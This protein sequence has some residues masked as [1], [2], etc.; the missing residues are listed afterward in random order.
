MNEVVLRPMHSKD[1]D[2]IVEMEQICFTTPW[3][4]KSIEQEYDNNCAKWCVLEQNDIIIAYGGMWIIFDEAHII[5]IAVHPDYRQRGY[6]TQIMHELFK[7][8]KKE[9]ATRMTLEVRRSNAAAQK[10]YANM[11]FVPVGVRKRY[12]PDNYEDA[13]I[14]WND[15]VAKQLSPVI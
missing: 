6:G 12:Y 7:V 1:I 14:L 8:A 4:R 10:L 11:G 9:G 13:L 15:D 5:N 2:I 3:S